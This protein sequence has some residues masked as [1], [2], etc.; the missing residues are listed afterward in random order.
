L[1]NAL[2]IEVE[3]NLSDVTTEKGEAS[4]QKEVFWSK[5][6]LFLQAQGPGAKMNVPFEVPKDGYYEVIA[7]IAQAPD[8]GDYV[9]TLDGKQTNSTM[10]TWGPLAAQAPAVEILHNYQPEIFVGVDYRLGWFRLSKGR[11]VLAFTCVG[12]DNLSSGYNLGVDNVVLAEIANGEALVHATGA[13]LPRYETIEAGIPAHAPVAGVVYRGK[14]L[15]VYLRQ[16]EQARPEGR[17]EVIRSIG[18][19][20]E[21]AAPAISALTVALAD[22]DPGTRGAAAWTLAQVGRKAS[23]A[24]PAV[25]KLLQDANTPVRESAALALR[26]MG[27]GAVGAV[28]E[29]IAALKDPAPT[30]R[31]TAATALGQIGEAAPSGVPALAAA[32]LAP[33]EEVQVLRNIAYALGNIGPNARSAIPALQQVQ[34][35][36]IK[37][38]AEEAIARIEGKHIPTWH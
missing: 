12:K 24:A 3:N 15:S 16:L 17:A 5:D 1:G 32:L 33:D 38:I 14:P 23:E 30:V 34:H 19:F 9:A 13:G 21:D 2:Q 27:K 37:Y 18:A 10:V 31:M 35:L 36:R 28:A 11:H 22:P 6:L 25:A 26:Q 20:G 8:Y 29:L 4:V 7:A